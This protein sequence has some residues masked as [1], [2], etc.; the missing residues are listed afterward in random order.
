MKELSQIAANLK[1][2]GGASSPLELAIESAQEMK[3]TN[4]VMFMVDAATAP[5][6]KELLASIDEGPLSARPGELAKSTFLVYSP[7]HR[8]GEELL[9]ELT[10]IENN[11]KRSGLADR[12]FLSTLGSMKW[13]PTTNSLIFTGDPQSIERVQVILK[14]LDA[15]NA[16]LKSSEVFIYKPQHVSPDQIR[17]VLDSLIPGLQGTH[18]LF[19]TNLVN[20]IEQ[21]KW[22]PENQSFIVTTD[23]ATIER[24]KTLL[25]SIDTEQPANVLLSKGFFLYKLQNASCD[26]V[27]SELKNVVKK[28]PP[29]NLQN[30][31][32]LATVNRIECIPSNNSLLITGSND[33]IERAKALIAEFD[34]PSGAPAKTAAE[35]L[36]ASVLSGLR[37]AN[38]FVIYNP[39][40][41]SGEELISILC[42]FMQNLMA[43]GVA[44]PGLFDTIGSLKWIDKTHS[45]LISGNKESI[46]K[47]Q[48]L[49]VKFDIPGKGTTTPSIE[50][51]DNTSFLVYKLQYH[52]GNDIQTALQQVA[53]SLSKG[54]TS[55]AALVDAI[56]S[57]QWIEV[58]NSLLCSGQQDVLV[59]L[60]DL[61][62][63]LDIPLRQV[64]IEVLVINTT[65]TNQQ[66]FGLQ[67][68]G[69]LQYFN[70]TVLQ[71]GNFPVVSP[72]SQ[73]PVTSPS[74]PTTLNGI[75]GTSNL[76]KGGNLPFTNGFDLGVIG[77]IIMH[78]GKSFISLGSL[79]NALQQDS[80][81]TIILNPKI[82]TQDN[83]QSSVFV[84][85]N[86]PYTGAL[87]TNSTSSQTTT[88]NIEYRDVGVSL[89]ITP[90]LGDGDVI[91][92]EIVQDISQVINGTNV[93]QSNSNLNG[94]QTSHT[95]ME[96]RV[97]VPEQPL[98]RL[99]R[100]DQ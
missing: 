70:K 52:P 49:L 4:S 57:L 17:S 13:V 65:L 97:H 43:S 61:I 94:I 9:K 73:I 98:C 81:S 89:T 67:W 56:H 2:T 26:T 23:P 59:K 96:T 31:N 75:N 15:P 38:S 42:D 86:I 11:L 25:A 3:D 50:S 58:T 21:M 64:F 68:G 55:P 19:D 41:V 5:K 78:K 37:N 35:K 87:V 88:Q 80:D 66:N 53:T 10:D 63:N 48:Q 83:R 95:H 32:L 39:K 90:I 92:M 62:Q 36:N 54:S 28:L 51:I 99:K 27:L 79:L 85:Q 82:I 45:L 33:T 22:N 71:T 44:D 60:K 24:L 84:G 91:T 20:A 1:S 16:V 72:P 47:V 74:F 7:Q 6:L 93:T 40:Y 30:Q 76:P 18:T 100:N 29:T 34:I 69:Q 14:T 46:D 12:S 8:P 77:D